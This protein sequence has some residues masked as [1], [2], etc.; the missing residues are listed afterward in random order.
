MKQGTFTVASNRA[1]T[2][3]VYE[4]VLEGDTSAITVPGQFVNIRLCGKY[5]RRPLSVCAWAEDRLKVIYKVAG[6]GTEQL[7]GILPGTVLDLLTGLGNGFSLSE[8]GDRPLLVGGGT[9]ASPLYALA[10][11][12]I[13]RGKRVT[14]VLGFNTADDVFYVEEFR[15]LGAKV[16][17][18]TLDGSVGT[19]GFVTD[20]MPEEYSYIY[21]CGPEP[22][23]KAVSK[24]CATGAQFSFEARMGCGF[25]ACMGCTCR[26]LT[27]YKRICKDGPV[28]RKEEL[29]W[30]D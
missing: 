15:Q 28:M 26:T 8:A 5:L 1:L 12:L 14:V 6:S 13:A 25:G 16:R 19:K 24:A 18:A 9:G 11:E 27:G 30:E 29:T 21:S 17:V 22:M 23:M 7:S 4:L 2:H 10:E 20:A 3:N